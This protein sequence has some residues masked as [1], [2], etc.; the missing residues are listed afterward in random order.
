MIWY[1]DSTFDTYYVL[2][3]HSSVPVIVVHF[4]LLVYYAFDRWAVRWYSGWVNNFAIYH[5][6]SF[7]LG[8]HY[9]IVVVLSPHTDFL[10]P[11]LPFVPVLLPTPT[12]SVT[13]FRPALHYCAQW[14]F[15]HVY[16][17]S[18]VFVTTIRC[19][20]STNLVSRPY[21]T[22]VPRFYLRYHYQSIP[23]YTD[24]SI[25][26]VWCDHSAFGTTTD[27]PTFYVT[28]LLFWFIPHTFYRY[29][30]GAATTLFAR[31][32]R[33][34]F[35]T[36]VPPRFWFLFLYVRL[37]CT[38][39]VSFYYH[40]LPTTIFT[41]VTVT[42][43]P[44]RVL[45]FLCRSGRFVRSTDCAY[46]FFLPFP[47]YL[48]FRFAWV[49]RAGRSAV[50]SV[51]THTPVSTA[52]VP[53]TTTTVCV[54][55][56]LFD[57]IALFWCSF[58]FRWFAFRFRLPA[59]YLPF[60]YT[61]T[62]VTCYWWLHYHHHRY[63]DSLPFYVLSRLF[64]VTCDFDFLL[65][66]DA[67]LPATAYADFRFL[68][69]VTTIHVGSRSVYHHCVTPYRYRF[70]VPGYIRYVYVFYLPFCSICS[71]HHLPA[72]GADH[73]D[74]RFVLLFVT[75][76]L[77][78]TYT[79]YVACSLPVVTTLPFRSCV[80]WFTVYRFRRA[81]TVTVGAFDGFCIPLYRWYAVAAKHITTCHHSTVLRWAYISTLCYHHSRFY[82][83]FV[84]LPISL[85]FIHLRFVT[86]KFRS[87]TRGYTRF[88]FLLRYSAHITI[89]FVL[90]FYHVHSF[91]CDSVPRCNFCFVP[92]FFVRSIVR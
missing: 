88:S 11:A 45:P 2:P 61:T 86:E 92:V 34:W 49:S 9:T 28:L 44:I 33:F 74:S 89:P 30:H 73:R 51:Y 23:F 12:V 4:H 59:D 17:V 26:W 39:L 71:F 55:L 32:L 13:V 63:V 25:F 8:I 14:N 50:R 80:L 10:P 19:F 31:L 7:R 90:P 66:S 79:V 70:T 72:V 21:H 85:P 52:R 22:V 29:L 43:T 37:R 27:C 57:Y 1:G 84:L 82:E 47:H 65:V 15:V 75:F 83:F 42:V 24:H 54:V 3:F 78:L 48:P 16:S 77:P 68:N 41:F 67:Y 58:N 60:C 46:R 35:T 91:S 56:S 87:T 6:D 36:T 81:P 62:T 18:L 76:T 53:F 20:C 38:W 40:A 69:F 64:W 5:G